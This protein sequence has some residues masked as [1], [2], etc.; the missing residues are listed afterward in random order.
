MLGQLTKAQ[1]DLEYVQEAADGSARMW[2]AVAG[3]GKAMTLGQVAT[4]LVEAGLVASGASSGAL[5]VLTDDRRELRLV[6]AIGAIA[7]PVGLD[8][9]LPL[10]ASF[11]LV[12]AVRSRQELWISSP[13]ELEARYPDLVPEPGAGAWAVLPLLFDTIVEFSG[14]PDYER[15]TG[16]SAHSRAGRRRRCVSSRAVCFRT[17]RSRGCR[18]RTV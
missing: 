3:L 9:H 16:W 14:P 8:R 15:A 2:Q 17:P 13:A 5:V 4:Y 18:D 7:E 1:I 6:H 12:D 11:P 10:S